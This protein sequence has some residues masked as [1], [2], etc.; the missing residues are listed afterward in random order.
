MNK[1]SDSEGLPP[2][3]EPLAERARAPERPSLKPA[4]DLILASA[5]PRRRDLL[6]GAG[7]AIQI[8]PVEILERLSQGESAI[9]YV[10]R[11]ATEKALAGLAERVEGDSPWVL[12][13]DTTVTVAGAILGKPEDVNQAHAMLRSLSGREHVV[14]T[15]WCLASPAGI[16]SVRHTTTR[17]RFR[18]LTDSEIAAYVATG[19]PMDKAGAYGIQGQAGLFV[20]GIEGSYDGVVGLPLTAVCTDLVNAGVIPPFPYAIDS[21]LAAIEGRVAACARAAGRDVDEVQLI[22]VSKR[23]PVARMRRAWAAGLFNFGESYV[24]EW[25]DKA[26]QLGPGPVWHFVGRLQR[27]KARFLGGRIA[28]VHALDS[29]R[30]A[31]ALGRSAAERSRE[32]A[33]LAQ[34]NLVDEATKGGLSRDDLPDFIEV[35]KGIDGLQP[36]GLMT[37]P[38]NEGNAAARRRFRELRTLRDTLATQAHPLKELSMGMSG[39]FEA[40]IAEGSTMIR[41]GTAV[42]GPRP[43]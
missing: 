38:P 15:A 11:L 24:Q 28:V 42:F 3:D 29:R 23:Q 7:L 25:R 5:S 14:A 33:V 27:N 4:S 43:A 40:A 37:L 31:E 16:Q 17:V 39:D 12:G 8:R 18:P 2:P 6:R 32:I 1:N 30:T 35:L 36:V 10:R 20:E 21:R 26:C 13:C 19:E 41:I 34:V 22:G 9:D